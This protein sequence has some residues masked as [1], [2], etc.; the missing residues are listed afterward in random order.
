M[1]IT[2]SKILN[3]T[4]LAESGSHGGLVV[5][6]AAQK[7]LMDFFQ[8]TGV[9]RLFQDKKGMGDFPMHYVDYTSNRTTP[10][11]RI[12]SISRYAARH[13]LRPGDT[14]IFQKEENGGRSS[15]YI[16]Y[17]RKRHSVYFIG[18]SKESAEVLNEDLFGKIMENHVAAGR[19]EH[20][21]AAKYEMQ[22]KYKGTV[23]SLVIERDGDFFKILFAG[24]HIEESKKY[25]ELDTSRN[26]FELRKTDTW[27]IEIDM[28]PENVTLNEEADRDFVRKMADQ[29]LSETTEPY[30]PEPEEKKPGHNVSGRIVPDRD[31][32]TA[33]KALAR[34]RYLCEYDSRHELFLR[35]RQP[36]NYTE[37]HHL[38]PLKYDILFD[39]SLD[40]QANIVSLCSHCHNLI[41]YGAEAELVIRKLWEDRRQ[42]LKDAGL[43]V[44]SNGTELTIEILL[45]FYGIK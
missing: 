39:K 35:K 27:K 14:L 4:D 44:M 45:G 19:I 41:H 37:P 3:R 20:M 12:T 25:F 26:L 31:K 1:K 36:V 10:N 30:V 33:C 29:V 24:N 17:A 7:Q 15:Y 40:V 18:K 13:K 6:K 5:T 21:S 8:Q 11:D 22:A 32:G 2:I 16:D 38:I 43:G 9:E 23:G 42:E 28:D 34:A